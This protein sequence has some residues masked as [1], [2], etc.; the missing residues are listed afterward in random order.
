MKILLAF[1]L[2]VALPGL[3]VAQQKQ[4]VQS[5]LAEGYTIVGVM[6]SGAGPG[7]FLQK[8]G[9]LIACFVA[10]TPASE[11]IDTRYCKPVR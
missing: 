8:A 11:A 3:A 9:T 10:E 4:T 2:M 5:L 1:M 6:P 7:I